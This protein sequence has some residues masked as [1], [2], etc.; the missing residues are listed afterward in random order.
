MKLLAITIA[1]GLAG[2]VLDHNVGDTNDHL[3]PP[4]PPG[5]RIA[6]RWA[7]S[8]GDAWS[9]RA[10][11]TAIDPDGNVIVGGFFQ[12]QTDFGAGLVTSEQAPSCCGE[13]TEIIYNPA[14]F[15][16]KR[17]AADGSHMWTAIV[18][19]FNAA[20]VRDVGVDAA[21]N[22]Y[23][24]AMRSDD[25]Y[26]GTM[27]VLAMSSDGVELWRRELPPDSLSA[28]MAIAVAPD[29]TTY[30]LG[31]FDGTVDFGD[32][33]VQATH[34]DFWWGTFVLAY[35]PDGTR[36]WGRVFGG[37]G[38]LDTIV[39]SPDGDL[40]LSGGVMH[41]FNIGGHVV[42]GVGRADS[43]LA[44]MSPNGD[45][46]WARL[47]RPV[48]Y[49]VL[50]ATHLAIEADGAITLVGIEQ[51]DYDYINCVATIVFSPTGELRSSSLVEGAYAHHVTAG[52]EGNLFVT[53]E[54]NMA[55]ADFGNG[56]SDGRF[57]IAA[58]DAN[59][60]PGGAT[61]YT[62]L[63]EDVVGGGS[64]DACSATTA[65]LATAGYLEGD[66]DV[67]AGP[68]ETT[69]GDFNILVAMYDWEAP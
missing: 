55:S 2:C 37:S 29:G 56:P 19:G 67:G 10:E 68:L 5:P 60:A 22:V 42:T 7:I 18:D 52:P 53:G 6:P 11:S 62:P 13:A 51:R 66:I 4:P 43:V 35:D 61:S 9:D 39:L 59:A 57:F 64:F 31:S 36:L 25:P 17:A 63:V 24:V 16:T 45:V 1:A 33:P 41:D 26:S 47:V 3:D 44:R 15:V 21:G 12:H 8:L 38:G 23:A 54:I 30:V 14:G 27:V 69:P 50:G 40:V 46:E 58:Y 32:G 48:A 65:G 28:G 49:D 34:R 20:E